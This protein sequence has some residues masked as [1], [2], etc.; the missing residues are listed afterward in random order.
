[1]L[2]IYCAGYILVFCITCLRYLDRGACIV[3]IMIIVRIRIATVMIMM[4]PIEIIMI[5]LK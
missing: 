2:K 4:I 3:I 5:M 1:M